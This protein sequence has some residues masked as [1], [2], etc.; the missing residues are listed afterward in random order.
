MKLT[1]PFV[2][3]PIVL[4]VQYGVSKNCRLYPLD[5]IDRRR[6]DTSNKDIQQKFIKFTTKKPHQNP[7]IILLMKKK[8]QTQ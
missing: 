4:T 5:I 8:K 2:N 6:L 3:V 7:Y 1:Q